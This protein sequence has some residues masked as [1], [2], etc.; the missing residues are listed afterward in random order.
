[1]ASPACKATTTIKRIF[2]VRTS[3]ALRTGY[4]YLVSG[5]RNNLGDL[6]PIQIAEKK[7]SGH[8]ESNTDKDI[9]E[10]WDCQ[11]T[12]HSTRRP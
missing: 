11:R 2:D 7:Q 10:N 5:R 6:G 9:I 12:V 4:L 8:A 3:V 1:M